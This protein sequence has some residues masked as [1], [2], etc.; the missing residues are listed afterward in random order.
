MRGNLPRASSVLAEIRKMIGASDAIRML[1]YGHGLGAVHVTIGH[2]AT[3]AATH[4]SVS[5]DWNFVGSCHTEDDS[6]SVGGL[7]FS[8]WVRLEG[9]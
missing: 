9:T 4:L 6:A 8:R 7:R 2:W 5:P 1:D 3:P